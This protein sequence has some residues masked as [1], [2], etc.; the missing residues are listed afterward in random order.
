MG[1]RGSGSTRPKARTNKL[2]RKYK[3]NMKCFGIFDVVL[4]AKCHQRRRSVVGQGWVVRSS[5]LAGRNAGATL[6]CGAGISGIPR[7][8]TP[9]VRRKPLGLAEDVE[10]V[11]C[12][13][14]CEHNPQSVPS[15]P[16]GGVTMGQAISAVSCTY[17]RCPSPPLAPQHLTKPNQT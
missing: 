4:F 3:F 17:S 5:R 14:R 6:R 1:G 11:L 15:C 10:V 8:A 16:A 2:D 13:A 12:E 7:V 9:A